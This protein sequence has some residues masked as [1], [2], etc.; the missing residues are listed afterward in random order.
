MCI[1]AERTRFVGKIEVRG[2]IAECPRLQQ[3]GGSD[4]PPFRC[5]I[6]RSSA[7]SNAPH[8]PRQPLEASGGG[9]PPPELHSFQLGK[10][11]WCHK[12]CPVA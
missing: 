12:P 2:R 3:I 10:S 8:R 9:S 1:R 7:L 4:D 11:A 6:V 5:K